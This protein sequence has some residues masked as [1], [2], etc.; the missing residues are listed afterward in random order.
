[1]ALIRHCPSR[2]T[3]EPKT[4]ES[5][6]SE[7]VILDKL[8]L[9]NI[10]ALAL[11]AARDRGSEHAALDGQPAFCQILPGVALDNGRPVNLELT[12]TRSRVP[13]ACG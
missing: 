8:P 3:L 1:M 2:A 12:E 5:N 4:P 10:D 9:L 11:R 13:L 6:K 7:L